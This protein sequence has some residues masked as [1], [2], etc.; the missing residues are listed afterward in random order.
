MWCPLPCWFPCQHDWLQEGACW[1]EITGS[2]DGLPESIF[3]GDFWEQEDVDQRLHQ[4]G[5]RES[6]IQGSEPS[7]HGLPWAPTVTPTVTYVSQLSVPS[8]CF[9]FSISQ[10]ETRATSHCH[11][12]ALPA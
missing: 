4:L 1:G 7:C 8:L 3:W 9:L 11:I 2:I 12:S 6:L 10:D 5:S